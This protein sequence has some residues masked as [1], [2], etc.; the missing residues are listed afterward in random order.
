M[1]G[2]KG[3]SSIAEYILFLFQRTK[4]TPSTTTTTPTLHN[5]LL[6]LFQCVRNCMY[7]NMYNAGYMFALNH[8][9]E[10]KI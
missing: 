6:S 8:L 10:M 3:T 7:V 5:S 2:K 1:L 4:L 9:M